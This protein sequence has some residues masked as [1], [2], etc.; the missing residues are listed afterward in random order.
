MALTSLSLKITNRWQM[1]GTLSV[2]ITSWGSMIWSTLGLGSSG[3]STRSLSVAMPSSSMADTWS[4]SDIQYSCSSWK[5]TGHFDED[6]QALHHSTCTEKTTSNLI[7]F[8]PGLEELHEGISLL[9]EAG[10]QTTGLGKGQGSFKGSF[11]LTGCPQTPTG[12]G[13]SVIYQPFFILN[14]LLKDGRLPLYPAQN[15]LKMWSLL[16]ILTAYMDIFLW[17][18]F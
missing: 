8:L 13:E 5:S 3:N 17:T 12:H 14:H 10:V 1:G 7:F 16:T 4:R 18:L 6:I 2:V 15:A 11:C 9:Y